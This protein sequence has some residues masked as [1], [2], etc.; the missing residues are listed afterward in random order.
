MKVYPRTVFLHYFIDF[1]SKRFQSLQVIIFYKK[2]KLGEIYA[3]VLFPKVTF[4]Q[5]AISLLESPI[6][7]FS[8]YASALKTVSIVMKKVSKVSR[9]TGNYL[10]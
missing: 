10:I 4:L 8:S 9:P 6:N 1:S 3:D 2:A 5:T 7:S